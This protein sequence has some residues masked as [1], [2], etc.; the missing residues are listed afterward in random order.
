MGKPS[1]GGS[2]TVT[3]LPWGQARQFGRQTISEAQRLANRDKLVAAPFQSGMTRDYISDLAGLGRDNPFTAQTMGNYADFMG[4][5]TNAGRVNLSGDQFGM[6]RIS[7]FVMSKTLPQV[8]GMFGQGGF[9]NSTM[10]QQT[11]ADAV[12]NALT[13]FAQQQFNLDRGRMDENAYYNSALGERNIDRG[14]SRDLS[15]LGLAPTI[16]GMQYADLQAL[17]QAGGM[18]DAFVMAQRNNQG[19]N[20]RAATDLFTALGGMGGSQTSTGGGPGTLETLGGI[21]Q[22]GVN[23]AIANSLLGGGGLGAGTWA[24]GGGGASALFPG[25]AFCDRRLKV[26]I[27]PTGTTY[28]GVDLYTFR[29]LWDEPDVRR[30]GPMAQEVPDHAR[31]TLPS[32]FL[33]VD[34]G[35][36]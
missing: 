35:A 8:A 31:V 24:L 32:G 26:D 16:S 27:E 19:D 18:R 13:P 22:L 33:A 36:L 4:A 25:M 21:G 23:A 17:G 20:V 34:M 1:G 12:T 2:Q 14:L 10:A 6:D 5:N 30:I 28:R 11:A 3:Q 29:Y 7:D 15:G 9:A